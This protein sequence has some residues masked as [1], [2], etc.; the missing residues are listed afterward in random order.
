[1]IVSIHHHLGSGHQT[2]VFMHY[3]KYVTNK[4]VSSALKAAP[5]EQ[6]FLG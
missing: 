4:V 2:Y 6:Y 1:M 5:L 3:S